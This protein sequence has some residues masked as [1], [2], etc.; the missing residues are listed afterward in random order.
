[1]AGVGER[2]QRSDKK[3]EV[4]PLIPVDAKEVIFRL[5]HITHTPLKD[6]GEF[7]TVF[8]LQDKDALTDLSEHFKRSVG[9]DNT[10]YNGNI[11]ARTIDKRLRVPSDLVA[12]RFK[13]IDF[14]RI[15]VLAF[16]LDCTPTRA[17][18]VLLEQATRDIKAV[19][20]YVYI[21]MKHELTDGQMN[22]LRKVLSYVN[23]YNNNSHS[24]MS[25]LSSIVGDIRP[26]T[27]KLYELVNEFLKQ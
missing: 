20:E 5:S 11:N 25:L 15:C 27:K 8:M 1:M 10:L 2:K 26:A 3:R 21:N 7:L 16:A 9:I 23:R 4:K 17:T 19:N 6:V 14:E 13:R 18:A 22:E 12:I 24:W